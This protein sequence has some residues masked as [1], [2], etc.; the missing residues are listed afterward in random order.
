MRSSRRS[1]NL[2][3]DGQNV[4]L[5]IL[6]FLSDVSAA[7]AF[8]DLSPDAQNGLYYVIAHAESLFRGSPAE[9][10][11]GAIIEAIL[12]EEGKSQEAYTVQVPEDTMIEWKGSVA[13]LQEVLENARR[14]DSGYAAIRGEALEGALMSLSGMEHTFSQLL[15]GK[16][17]TVPAQ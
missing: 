12:K 11:S 17:P 14:G 3:N 16:G 2:G 6:S 7:H 4:G 9:D 5:S 13:L 15:S 10:K 1:T 8:D